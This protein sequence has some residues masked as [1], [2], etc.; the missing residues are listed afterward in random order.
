MQLS[1]ELT[2]PRGGDTTQ[3][4]DEMQLVAAAG[5]RIVNI[6]DRP[7]GRARMDSVTAALAMASAGTESGAR[8]ESGA[9][10]GAPT[11]QPIVHLAARRRTLSELDQ[12][13]ARL[14]AAGITTALVV[15]GDDPV[16]TTDSGL[17]SLDVLEHVAHA[18]PWL[19]AGAALD[20]G[21]TDLARELQRLK[22]KLQLGAAF[23]MTQPLR[24]EGDHAEGDSAQ[25]V[26]QCIAHVAEVDVPVWFGVCDDDRARELIAALAAHGVDG[27]QLHPARGG[28]EHALGLLVRN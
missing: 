6:T 28:V 26:A 1:V 15:S 3:L 17:D 9:G 27:I 24:P 14:H 8:T 16:D 19:R 2:P 21:A 7:G 12:D 20:L 4:L 13:L 23:L 10:T 18:A 11:P 5:V 22:R 25:H